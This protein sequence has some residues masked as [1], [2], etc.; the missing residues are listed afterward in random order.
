MMG[1]PKEKK[2]TNFSWGTGKQ[3][4][5]DMQLVLQPAAKLLNIDVARF[6]IHIKP[7]EK[8]FKNK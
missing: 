2:N 5:E 8:G 3:A 6:T 7:R 1:A 4:T